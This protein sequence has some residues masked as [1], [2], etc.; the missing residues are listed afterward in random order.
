MLIHCTV[1]FICVSIVREHTCFINT[2]DCIFYQGSIVLVLF[3]MSII[4]I[5]CKLSQN[6]YL[7]GCYIRNITIIKNRPRKVITQVHNSSHRPPS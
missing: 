7:D 5:H 2:N 6:N 3:F 4:L 1:V